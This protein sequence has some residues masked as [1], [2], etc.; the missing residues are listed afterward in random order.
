MPSYYDLAVIADDVYNNQSALTGQRIR[1]LQGQSGP[2]TDRGFFAAPY[3]CNGTLVIAF[4][5][6]NDSTD[7]LGTNFR[8]YSADTQ[9]DPAK[10]F[11]VRMIMA[12][13]ASPQSVMLTGH[14]LGGALAKYAA[15]VLTRA[16]EP[17]AATV[18]FNAPNLRQGAYAHLAQGMVTTMAS[19]NPVTGYFAH[20]TLRPRGDLPT[21]SNQAGRVMNV[22]LG[23]DKVSRIGV[24]LG[25][26]LRLNTP[27]NPGGRLD[28]HWAHLME[29]VLLALG[30]PTAFGARDVVT[31]LNGL[32]RPPDWTFWQHFEI[33]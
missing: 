6:S 21:A 22:R 8:L 16:G 27:A 2:R 3:E 32:G 4:C 30:P 18:A 23:K 7:W 24:P 5:G 29:A 26:T 17:P 20:R 25:H 9:L 19:T 11:A 33:G 13:G 31:H 28:V 14:S 1:R 12:H 15:L 10:D